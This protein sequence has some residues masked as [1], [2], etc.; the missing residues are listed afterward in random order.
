MR[1]VL[2]I[3]QTSPGL[4]VWA[5]RKMCR[6]AK[7]RAISAAAI[8]KGR[9]GSSLVRFPIQA[10]LKPNATRMRGPRQHVEARMAARPPRK[11]APEPARSREFSTGPI[12]FVTP[13]VGLFFQNWAVARVLTKFPVTAA[14]S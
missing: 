6:P 5:D 11:S 3:A 9:Y 8:K 13:R 12:S 1:R 14:Q 10:P 7:N 4:Q 2:G